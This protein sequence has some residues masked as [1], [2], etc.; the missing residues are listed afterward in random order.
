MLGAA[1]CSGAVPGVVCPDASGVAGDVS[2][3]CGVVLG[4]WG[5]VAGAD[6][7]DPAVCPLACGVDPDDGDVLVGWL[8]AATQMAD[9]S[10]M[11]NNIDFD[12][13]AV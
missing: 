11:E 10:N 12:L 7:W 9:N 2:G 6:D 5:A 4:V 13:M 3:V 1:F 8:W